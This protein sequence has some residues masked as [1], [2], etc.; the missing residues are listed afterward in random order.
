LLRYLTEEG[1]IKAKWGP[2]NKV[3]SHENGPKFSEKVGIF[4]KMSISKKVLHFLYEAHD[5]AFH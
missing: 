2:E 5:A 4:Q 3:F 1:V